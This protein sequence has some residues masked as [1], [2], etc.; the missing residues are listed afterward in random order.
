MKL[1]SA[2]GLLCLL[3]GLA[4]AQQAASLDALRDA[5]QKAVS[6][7]PEVQ[8]RVHAFNAAREE[9]GVAQGGYFPRVDVIASAGR[10][11]LRQPGIDSQSFNRSLNSIALT[12]MLWDGLG[13]RNEVARLGHAKLTRYYELLDA[14]DNAALEAA[15]A[16]LDVVRYRR[17]VML[18]EENYVQHRSVH[19]QIQRKVQ[20][21]A[22][23]RVDFEQAAGRLALAESNLITE[24]ANLH[25]VTARYQRLVG[26]MPPPELPAPA[27]LST[28]APLSPDAAQ[29][30]AQQRSP[31]LAAAIENVRAA[32]SEAAGRK[33]A[34]SP[35]VDFRLRQDWDRN[36]DGIEGRRND[37]VAEFVVNYNLF[38]GGSDIARTRQFAERLNNAKDL[39]DKACRDLRQTVAIA[40]NDTRKIT[41]QLRYLDQHQT[42]IEKARDA[43]R[44]QFDIG[45]R[46]LLDLLD[47]ENELFQAR[48]AYANADADL[49]IAYARVQAGTGNMLPALQLKKPETADAPDL[50]NWQSSPDAPEYCPPEAPLP[51]Q[52]DKSA[53]DTRALKLLPTPPSEPAPN[54]AVPTPRDPQ[55]SQSADDAALRQAVHD[56]AAAWSA[57][58]VE[59]Y[60]DLYAPDFAV[61]TSRDQWLAQR[62]A[63]INRA[64]TISVEVTELKIV[65]AGPSR[66]TATFRQRYSS[67]TFKDDALKSLD[68]EKLDGRWLIVRESNR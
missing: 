5:A 48:R 49:A 52:T 23:R 66:A 29:Q 14:A 61:A 1:R 33:A 2:I 46:T 19:E 16:Y 26:E 56:W 42:S 63:R 64:G 40:Y 47:T 59:R 54:G 17:L 35:R 43:Y 51:L 3:P 32:Q 7:N 11:R 57:K 62:R 30:Q 10:E 31:A 45:Q 53:L 58:N 18:A 21:G 15:R 37:G 50:G 65:Q 4:L 44:K 38:N 60:A 22:G 28:D 25:D 68:W 67:D 39:R 12:Q 55:S 8:A 9:V 34:F 36:R 41:E 6:S 13:T 20:A 24:S 27:P